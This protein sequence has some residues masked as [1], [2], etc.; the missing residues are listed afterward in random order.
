M[1]GIDA[2]DGGGA[3]LGTGKHAAS[4]RGGAGERSRV[5]FVGD[6]LFFCQTSEGDTDAQYLV[7]CLCGWLF[8]NVA[9]YSLIFV[10]QHGVLVVL[11][12]VAPREN[13]ILCRVPSSGAVA[14]APR[15]RIPFATDHSRLEQ[16]R[17]AAR[18]SFAE[19]TQTPSPPFAGRC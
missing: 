5:R 1:E 14:R 11:S 8:V 7:R 13:I 15:S 6:A 3:R 17:T 12:A 10:I 4:P 18:F 9:V 2:G 16:Q 19:E